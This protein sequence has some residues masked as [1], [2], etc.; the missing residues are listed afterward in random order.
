MGLPRAKLKGHPLDKLETFK[1]RRYFKT[2][3]NKKPG[4]DKGLFKY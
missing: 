2:K 3:Q 1:I 4:F